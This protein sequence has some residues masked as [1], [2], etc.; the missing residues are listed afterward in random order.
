MASYELGDGLLPEHRDQ[1]LKLTE[2]VSVNDYQQR[3]V[4]GI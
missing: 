3:L 2:R 4:G 1:S